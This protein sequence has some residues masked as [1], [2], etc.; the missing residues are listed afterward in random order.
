MT[1]LAAVKALNYEPLQSARSLSSNFS[2]T[3]GLIVLQFED[4]GVDRAG[5][6][7]LASLHLGAFSKCS[8][9]GFGLMLARADTPESVMALVR[10]ALS[11]NVGGYVVAAPATELKG[12]MEALQQNDIPHASISPLRAGSADVVIRARERE[13]VRDLVLHLAATGHRDIGYLSHKPPSWG[14]Q[15][16]MAGYKAAMKK[17]GLPVRPEWVVETTGPSVAEGVAAARAMLLQEPRPTAIQCSMDDLAACAL[18]AAH[19]MGLRLP[20][21]LSVTGFDDYST[22][23][24]VWPPLSTIHLPV[25]EMAAAAV[26]EVIEMLEGRRPEGR[27]FDCAVQLRGSISTPSEGGS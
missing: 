8:E 14:K 12:L 15:E 23:S 9:S 25:E 11:R 24:K 3:I 4:K 21:D 27:S 19:E 7:Y 5:Y 17:L 18:R 26:A 10:S 2:R 20:A 1:V 22:A 13:A 16:R 6:E